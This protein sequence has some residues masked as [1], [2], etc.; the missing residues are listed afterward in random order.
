[1]LSPK[2][3]LVGDFTVTRLAENRFWLLGAGVMQ[4]IHMR[5]FE[6]R[7]PKDGSVKVENQSLRYAGLQIAG[8]NA[9]TLLQRRHEPDYFRAALQQLLLYPE[10]SQSAQLQQA[11]ERN[12]ALFFDLILE[13]DQLMTSEQRRFLTGKITAMA[14]DF[15]Q[16]VRAE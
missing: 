16:L 1:M 8:P 3:R 12:L 2:G 14:D 7:L 10:Q 13:I 6:T 11:R 5:W 4:R 9:R 15:A